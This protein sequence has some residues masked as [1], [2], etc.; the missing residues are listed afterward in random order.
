MVDE[1]TSNNLLAAL[2]ARVIAKKTE[3]YATLMLYLNNPV[4][5]AEHPRVI[6][7]LENSLND[8]THA[9]D[10]LKTL[11]KYFHRKDEPVPES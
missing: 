4:A 8:L 6:D 10:M 9:E 2:Q 3:A 5:V 11:N 7:E 1:K